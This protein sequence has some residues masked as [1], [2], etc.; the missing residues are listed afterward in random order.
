MAASLKMSAAKRQR[1]HS[2]S[3]ERPRRDAKRIVPMRPMESWRTERRRAVVGEA[4][5]S[6][7]PT[8]VRW[9]I[10]LGIGR[11]WEGVPSRTARDAR[12]PAIE[13]ENA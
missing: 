7:T 4:V 5:A 8:P 6:P 9:L 10:G 13:L 2:G 3:R 12:R 1:L 11:G